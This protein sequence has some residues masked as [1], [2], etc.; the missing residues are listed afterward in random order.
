M[1]R[2]S[3]GWPRGKNRFLIMRR[4]TSIQATIGTRVIA[5]ENIASP[6]VNSGR[7]AFGDGPRITT[8]SGLRR[9]CATSVKEVAES[10][11]RQVRWSDRNST[12]A[13]TAI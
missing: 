9:L 8:H 13:M 1:G 7:T 6:Y 11:A 10:D 4:L 3:R 5:A 12:S 2:V